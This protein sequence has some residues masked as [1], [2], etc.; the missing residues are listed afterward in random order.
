MTEIEGA[1]LFDLVFEFFGGDTI[2]TT[3]W[4]MACNPMLGNVSPNDMIRCGRYKKLLKFIL[5]SLLENKPE[6]VKVNHETA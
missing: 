3:S 2:K 5:T 1:K 4:F 6:N